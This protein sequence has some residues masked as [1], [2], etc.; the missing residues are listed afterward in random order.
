MTKRHPVPCSSAAKPHL[1]DNGHREIALC[2]LPIIALIISQPACADIVAPPAPNAVLPCLACSC[3]S[4]G[5]VV[6]HRYRALG[7]SGMLRAVSSRIISI[8]VW[9]NQ[10]LEAV[11][12]N[13]R[14][15]CSARLNTSMNSPR[16][17]RHHGCGSPPITRKPSFTTFAMHEVFAHYDHGS[18]DGELMILLRTAMT[19][20]W[21]P[22]SLV[23]VH[24]RSE[25]TTS[26]QTGGT[27]RYQHACEI[28]IECFTSRGFLRTA[29]SH[30]R[31][32][33]VQLQH[34]YAHPSKTSQVF[35][36]CTS[37]SSVGALHA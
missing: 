22:S 6:R 9:F 2:I 12:Q 25:M 1:P 30:I 19:Q 8:A 4:H 37:R 7:T 5:H 23:T 15:S 20:L 31:L 26:Q 36:A 34:Y 27:Q 29:S 35:S 17:L 3:V 32:A 18:V 14:L 13:F 24:D 16:R 33:H 28:G 11:E 10:D 21:V